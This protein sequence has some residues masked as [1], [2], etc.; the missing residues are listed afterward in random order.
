M[1]NTQKHTKMER[2]NTQSIENQ[3]NNIMKTYICKWF[4]IHPKTFKRVKLHSTE[5][6]AV[7][8]SDAKRQLDRHDSVIHSITPIPDPIIFQNFNF[9]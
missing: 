3:T 1:S 6:I 9:N 5:I 8:I 4:E 7:S 2:K